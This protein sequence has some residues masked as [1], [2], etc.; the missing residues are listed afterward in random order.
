[1][2]PEN[3]IK[4]RADGP[5]LCSGDIAVYASDGRLLERSADLVLCRCGQSGNKPFCDGSHRANGFRDAGVASGAQS[6]APPADGGTLEISVRDNAMLIA[7]GPLTLLNADGSLAAR[8][9]KAALC[10]CGHSANKPFCDGSHRDAGFQ[11]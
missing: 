9:C 2:E 10:R 7:R 1:M 4:V 6:D 5:L 8:R 3:R 11:G